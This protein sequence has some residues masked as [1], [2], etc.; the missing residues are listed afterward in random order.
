MDYNFTL[1]SI[2]ETSPIILAVIALCM[3]AYKLANS[4]SRRNRSSDKLIT[5]L[6]ILSAFTLIIAQS[7]WY[8]AYVIM[9]KPED[10]DFSNWLWTIFNN[11][12]ML[13]LIIINKYNKK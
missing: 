2:F 10:T 1:R 12:S 6:S 4:K 3:I 13:I 11:V 7:S 8:V 9:N 5:N